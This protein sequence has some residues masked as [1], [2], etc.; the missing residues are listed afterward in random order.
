[1]DIYPG[2]VVGLVGESGCG[3]ST[4]SRTILQLVPPTSGTVQFCGTDLT[5]L[6][7][8][9]IAAAATADPDGVSRPPCLFKPD[10]DR[11]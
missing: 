5:A 2:E 11:G 8:R 3:K 6:S 9:E 7:R 10:D 4:L 1:M